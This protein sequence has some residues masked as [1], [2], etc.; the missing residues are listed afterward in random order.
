MKIIVVT[1]WVLSWIWK[2]ITAA[3]IWAIL[4]WWWF[5]VFMQKFDWYLN[6]DPWTMS[7]FQHWE[8]FVTEDWTETDL[9]LGHYERFIDTNLNKYSSFTSWKLYEEVLKK[10]RLGDYLWKTVQIIPH[11]TDL[12]KSKIITWYEESNADVSIVEIWWTVWDMENE[13]FL[14]SVR[15]LQTEYW[16]ENVIFVHLTL[17]PYIVAS[18]EL[19]TKPTQHSVRELM[20]YW[21]IPD[22]IILRADQEISDDICLKVASFCDVQKEFVI[23]AT[24]AKSIYEVPLI[25]QSFNI[26]DLILKKLKIKNRN[27]DLKNWKDLVNNISNS[28]EEI[29]I[30]M[31]WKY[32]NLEDAYFSLNEWLK[33]AWFYY[34]KKINLVFIDATDIEEKWIDLLRNVDWICIPWWFWNRGIEWMILACNYARLNNIPYLWICLWSQVMAIE[35]ARNALWINL[36]NSEEFLP[37]WQENVVHIMEEQKWID[38][39]WWTMRLWSYECLL[40]KWTLAYDIYKKDIITERHRHRFEFN[41]KYREIMNEKWFIISWTSLDW[42]LVE[43]VEVENHKFMIWTQA[44]PELK[45][46]PTSPHVLFLRF[47]ESM[48]KD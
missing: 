23:P 41:N 26:W 17:L 36:A 27:F 31:V 25:F 29:N 13:Y 1:G 46:R 15:Q 30:A 43:V 19:K 9:D 24:T 34:N 37:D 14:E 20:S 12:V 11:L 7:P 22:F 16:K 47:I 45:S 40:K 39:K 48:K 42:N 18:K 32:N 5:N 28:K 21:I 44:H 2:W 35:F 10:E 3:S 4:K 38:K 6:V 33:T 8:V